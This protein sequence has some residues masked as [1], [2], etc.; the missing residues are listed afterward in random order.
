MERYYDNDP[1]N[2]KEP[3][4]GSEDDDNEE[5]EE[6]AIAFIDQQ[7]IVDMMHMDL[8]Q[9]ELNQQ[10]LGKAIEI[11]KQ[12]WFWCFKSPETKMNEIETIY[13][14]LIQ[15]TEDAKNDESEEGEEKEE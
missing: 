9:T 12:S 1:D 5:M 15:M 13:K 2:E 11:A 6:E 10:L 14:R 7:S 4:F 8:A 3:F